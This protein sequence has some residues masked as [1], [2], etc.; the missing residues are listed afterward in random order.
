MF[1][2]NKFRRNKM[3]VSTKK[4]ALILSII[5]FL[6]LVF[7]PPK[8]HTADKKYG[9]A[10]IHGDGWFHCDCTVTKKS[11]TCPVAEE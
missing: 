6:V 9:K 3:N 11:C 4:V 5:V 10:Y 8:V 7:A 1:N 2:D